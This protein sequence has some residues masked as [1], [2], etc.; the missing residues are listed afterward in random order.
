MHTSNRLETLL[1]G[2]LLEPV[3]VVAEQ[4]LGHRVA[5]RTALRWSLVGRN[6]VRLPTVR[7]CRRVHCTT[8]AAFRSWLE[9]SSA[10][11]RT[12]AA[13]DPRET[14]LVRTDQVADAVLASFGLGRD[15]VRA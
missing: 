4:V 13:T 12:L 6:G 1:A 5:S 8:V 15:K 9:A 11:G 3:P 7:G 2:G 14:G 10:D